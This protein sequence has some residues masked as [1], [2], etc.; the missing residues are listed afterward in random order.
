MNAHP[1]A[2]AH[3]GLRLF[4]HRHHDG[5]DAVLTSRARQRGLQHL[6]TATPWRRRI[7][8]AS[9]EGVEREYSWIEACGTSVMR[10]TSGRAERPKASVYL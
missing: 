4:E 1:A 8:S 5:V 7:R 2:R 10:A 9:A 6:F 3:A